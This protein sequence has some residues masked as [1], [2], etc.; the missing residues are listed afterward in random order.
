MGSPSAS[1]VVVLSANCWDIGLDVMT[2]RLTC[3]GNL[4]VKQEGTLRK[5]PTTISCLSEAFELLESLWLFKVS[6]LSLLRE[7]LLTRVL[8]ND[9]RLP[10]GCSKLYR[11]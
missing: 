7:L 6:N 11:F 3:V 1:I 4:F 9:G 2:I 8:E 5:I 10:E